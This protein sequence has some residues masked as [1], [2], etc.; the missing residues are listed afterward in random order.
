MDFN[1]GPNTRE[2]H[3]LNLFTLSN[4]RS[5]CIL[6]NLQELTSKSA[7]I[8]DQIISNIP[9]SLRNVEVLDPISTCD[10]CPIRA[11]VF[12]KHKFNKPKCY[13]RHIWQYNL[14]DYN[15]F[16][17]QLG[18]VDWNTC[19][20]GDI[21]ESCSRWTTTF[22]NIARQCIPNKVV[23]IRPNDKLF[24]TPELRRLRRKKNRMHKLAKKKNTCHYWSLFREI[25]N[26]YNS[27]IK[28]AK[29]N[30]EIKNAENLKDPE[31]LNSKKWWKLAKSFIKKDADRSSCYPPLNVNDE[32]ITDDIE[33]AEAFNSHFIKFSEINDNDVPVPDNSPMVD[34]TLAELVVTEKDVSDLLKSL[35]VKKASGPDQISHRML[36]EAGDKIST[37]LAKLFNKSLR[38]NIVPALWKKANVT[39][40]FKKND[41]SL[42]DNY[43]PVSLLSCVGKLFERTVF[44]YVFNFLRDTG[45]I[46]LKQSGFMPGDSTVYQL[47]HLYHIFSEA[48]DKQKDIRVVF[49]DISKAFDRVWHSGLLSKLSRTGI[50]GNLLKWFTN[51]LSDRK[52]RVVINGQFSNW[53]SV[54]AGVPQGSVLGPLLF[55]IY[56]NDITDEVQSSDV[57]LFADDTILYM[58]IDN[59]VLSAQALNEDLER[60][61]SW[62]D[63]WLVKFSTPKTKTMQISKKKKHQVSPPILMNGTRVNEVQSHKHLGVTISNN[64]TWNDHIEEMV[65][66]AGKSLDIL[67]ALKYKLD[68]VT[69]ERLYFAFVRSKLEYA[70]IVWDNCSKYLSDLVESVQYRAGK[71]V[72]G[73]IQQTSHELLYKELGWERLEDRRKKQRLKVF[74]KTINGETPVYLQNVLNAQHRGNNQYVLRNEH[75][76]PQIRSR[77]TSFYESYFPQ[78]IKDW[79]SLQNDIK[80]SES[81]NIFL[82]RLNAEKAIVPKWY[83]TGRRDISVKHAKLRM[84]C[85]NLNDHLFS[86]IHVVESPSCPCGH[87]RENNKHYLLECHMFYAERNV[88]L[89][90]LQGIGFQPSLQNLLYGNSQYSDECNIQAFDIIQNFIHVTGRL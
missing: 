60:I 6:K 51:Y 28:E 46:S 26:N 43:R 20:E 78:T 30:E 33:K 72:S 62:A 74:Y 50:T 12:L 89:N 79:N 66:T 68:R 15:L 52:Q 82:T 32:L 13:H 40:L 83:V 88:M 45:A 65:I 87:V 8:L 37:S 22:L 76:I 54:L 16:R 14:A 35:D 29:I 73:A 63:Q 71:I 77:T 58:F 41:N 57:R 81:T 9:C 34:Q 42:I 19:L 39:P 21:N 4:N 85:S 7:T 53:A 49:C 47:T 70:S 64:L 24:F 55:L 44:K 69:L 75:N 56:I 17:Q 23:I 38:A 1:A 31:N 67:N 86:H 80:N 90:E 10:H 36:K 11:S 59:P 25:R 18:S 61:S 3:F 2:G 48:L 5:L 27:K 84:L